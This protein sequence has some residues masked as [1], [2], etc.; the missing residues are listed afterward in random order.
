MSEQPEILSS[1][2]QYKLPKQ[3]WVLRY[4]GVFI[5]ALIFLL[6]SSLYALEIPSFLNLELHPTSS[7]NSFKA[8]TFSSNNSFKKGQEINLILENGHTTSFQIQN[9]QIKKEQIQL[10]LKATNITAIDSLFLN[11]EYISVAKVQKDS[12]PLIWSLLSI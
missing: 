3:H 9:I 11:T 7:K 5:V 1:N 8:T 6:L 2:L 10:D 4:S 12:K